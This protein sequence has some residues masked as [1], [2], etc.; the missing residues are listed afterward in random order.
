MLCG[1]EKELT[2][3]NMNKPWINAKLKKLVTKDH[4]LYDSNHMKCPEQGI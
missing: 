4:M 2:N 1:H 3:D